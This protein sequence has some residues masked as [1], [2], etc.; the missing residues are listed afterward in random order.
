MIPIKCVQDL[1]EE[2]QTDSIVYGVARDPEEPRQ[3]G[4]TT[5]LEDCG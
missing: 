1:Y 5:K 3:D 4:I 2:D